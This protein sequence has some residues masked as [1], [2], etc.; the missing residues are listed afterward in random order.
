MG[1]RRPMTRSFSGNGRLSSSS[2]GSQNGEEAPAPSARADSRNYLLNVRP[3]N[4]TTF[5]SVMAH[6][7]EE[8]QPTF[9]T[10]LKS[11]AVSQDSNV[12]FSCVVSGYPEPEL[13]WYK[14]DMQMDRYCGLPKYEIFRSGKTHTLH[15]YNCTEDD[16]AI[17]QAS[18][19]NSKGIVSCSGVLEVGTMS[20]YKIHQRW[21][22]K[23]K[24]KAEIKKKELE[25]SRKRG[26]GKVNVQEG[27]EGMEQLRT[28][29]PDRVQRKRRSP[30][31]TH[32]TLPSS[33]EEREDKVKM[34]IQDGEARLWDGTVDVKEQSAAAAADMPNG[35]MAGSKGTNNSDS[36]KESASE[37]GNEFLT[38]I[39]E[40]VE[41][42][43]TRPPSKDFLAKKKKK[44]SNRMDGVEHSDDAGQG[45]SSDNDVSEGGMSVAQYLSESLRSQAPK[46]TV[47]FS[48]SEE[49][50]DV[51]TERA[52]QVT[53]RSN[54]SEVSED[55]EMMIH[56]EPEPTLASPVYFSLKDMYFGVKNDSVD[57]ALGVPEILHPE[58]GKPEENVPV[59]PLLTTSAISLE[60]NLREPEDMTK[61]NKSPSGE[62]I[63]RE[64]DSKLLLPMDIP[65]NAKSLV[66]NAMESQNSSAAE[67]TLR[68]DTSNQGVTF[69]NPQSTALELETSLKTEVRSSQSKNEPDNF[70]LS[71]EEDIKFKEKVPMQEQA[72]TAL[73][74]EAAEGQMQTEKTEAR[75][76]KKMVNIST[77]LLVQEPQ[78]ISGE[79]MLDN[80][81]AEAN[82]SLILHNSG[83]STLRQLTKNTQSHSMG[84]NE[85]HT[86]PVTEPHKPSLGS[87]VDIDITSKFL[88]I[89]SMDNLGKQ[90]PTDETGEIMKDVEKDGNVNVSV[91][92]SRTGDMKAQVVSCP[93]K[94]D[95]AKMEG[96]AAAGIRDQEN[97]VKCIDKQPVEEKESLSV[98]GVPLVAVELNAASLPQIDD[99]I[100]G[101]E[102]IE[103]L[104]LQIT[105][106]L[107]SPTIEA[108][109]TS[110]T[111]LPSLLI[112]IK[113]VSQISTMESKVKE[114]PEV[115]LAT[116][117]NEDVPVK[118]K[119]P[120][121]KASIE[122]AELVEKKIDNLLGTD[123]DSSC[124][125]TI[126]LPS[127]NDNR[128]QK[129]I[130]MEST[131][132]NLERTSII[133]SAFKTNRLPAIVVPP[134]SIT[135]EDNNPV[136]DKFS[137]S[138]EG[139]SVVKE[140]ESLASILRGVKKDLDSGKDF[141]LSSIES[142]KEN[143]SPL[144]DTETL[145]CTKEGSHTAGVSTK[146]STTDDSLGIPV[147]PKSNSFEALNLSIA[148]PSPE[149]TALGTGP[150]LQIGKQQDGL[151][152]SIEPPCV[153]EQEKD[154][155]ITDSNTESVS[156]LGKHSEVKAET[157]KN[158][159]PTTETPLL[160]TTA[161]RRFA[162]KGPPSPESLGVTGVP[163]IRVDSF[164]FEDK[165]VDEHTGKDTPPAVASCESSP[166]LKR[167]D[168]LTLIPSATPEELA[169]GAR[170]K[171]FVPKPK[172]EEPEGL[173]ALDPQSKKEEVPK[174][175][176]LSQDQEAP[177][178]SPG[179]SRRSSTLLQAPSGQQTPPTERRS[180][181]LSRKKSSLEVPKLYEERVDNTE[182]EVQPEEKVKQDPFRAPQVIRKIRAE[183]FSDAGGHL[184]L[185]C[186]FFNVLSDSTIKWYRDE[187]EILEMKRS[188]GDESQVALA[189]V[190]VTSRDCGVYSCSIEN[191]YGTDS[192]DVLLSAE[193]LSGL[194]LRE[195]LEVGE[196]IEMTPMLFT[197]GLA[198]SGYWGEKFFGRIMT[199]EVHIGEGCTHKACRVKVIYGLD[200]I[201]E[202]GS[203]CIIKVRNPIA[204]GTKQENHLVERNLEITK[205]ECKIQN[206]AR[207]YC[208]IFAAETRVIEN[209][210]PAPEIIPLHLI[211]RPANTIPYATVETDLGSC[212]MK[213]C[214]RDEGG[215]LL[216]R[217]VS[218]IEQKCCAFQH[219]IHQWTNGNLLV[220]ILEGVGL[221]IT[222]VGVATKSKGYQGLADSC[223]PRVFEQFITH[224]QCNYYCGLLSLRPLK[225]MD[226]LQ[227]HGKMKGS[228][229]PL[230]NRKAAPGSSSPQMQKKGI[231]S[232]QTIKKGTSSPKVAKKS[233]S[234]DSK[235]TVKHKTVEIP[236]SVKMR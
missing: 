3:E 115:P 58:T 123:V 166:R 17:Y 96:E 46:D 48:P 188:S 69:T 156:Q 176:R 153:R 59:A 205:Q 66:E 223:V 55:A 162:T 27:M 9:E 110:I 100:K 42:I 177:P 114:I 190:Q 91:V 186:Q 36:P 187:V 86:E 215:R 198:D 163:A 15:I 193:V 202:S 220:T 68:V 157:E 67:E 6:L 179:Q 37:N 33:L 28:V 85:G 89:S 120:E 158:C 227:Q 146:D 210:G 80:V 131:G 200:P 64:V 171:I 169:S 65:L 13:T 18:A 76:G 184:K 127:E 81:K 224:H 77:E 161:P 160:S 113:P 39:Y 78:F 26:K 8:T 226:T 212:Y 62:T 117:P 95:N 141:G 126:E 128:I 53:S 105:G 63:L 189:I 112:D 5:C 173:V 167:R 10:T 181:N 211:Y 121:P 30:G 99:A 172:P 25:E 90:L 196:E 140:S 155:K 98:S 35:F 51:D 208:K 132:E 45:G 29:S 14:D 72:A 207:E 20:E 236:K 147:L 204:Y 168:S 192:T 109:N 194:L 50:M 1:S 92:Q 234:G 133:T 52:E 73:P 139:L 150:S 118:V 203:T 124:V 122:R 218:E 209:F 103:V 23:L 136:N 152:S 182:P 11:K 144:N 54:A 83:E 32:T 12:K 174:R 49:S 213:Y 221:K 178:V 47:K 57:E 79:E 138:E 21:F 16:A 43:T 38:Y 230:L 56:K 82:K 93:I 31:E 159:P 143:I 183:P 2:S 154:K 228:R 101:V 34:H 165:N 74:T 225:S 197:K 4:R 44:I 22:H 195:D 70:Q 130:K 71:A 199:Q 19:R 7:T 137:L 94:E 145:P 134:I 216:M 170:R 40:T 129:P 191:E 107:E 61:V 232:P 135:Y 88:S 175:R 222:N 106:V 116:F 229:S 125:P 142:K 151:K 149:T 231:G 102:I 219:W 214:M 148:V 233:D 108:E 164:L 111:E 206:T 201:F 217:N 180:P 60:N 185:W 84:S 41:I 24:Q 97:E 87:T 75:A 235:T 104:D 119:I